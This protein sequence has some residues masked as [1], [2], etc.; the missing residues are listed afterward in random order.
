MARVSDA[1][2]SSPRP[3]EA[4]VSAE[5]AQTV[6]GLV[7]AL[8]DECCLHLDD[9]GVRIPAVDPASVAMV[10]LELS[11]D[12][13][14]AYEAGGGRIGVDVDRLAAVVGMADRGQRV[15]LAL[16]PETRTLEIVIDELEYTLAL[17]D[18]EA[19]RSPPDLSE[20]AV[21][22]TGEAVVDADVI[23][24]ALRAADMVA[25]QIAFGIDADAKTF[26]VEAEGDTDDVSLAL[27]ADD[28]VDFTPGDAHSLFSLDYLNAINRAIADAPDIGLQLG[29]E[30]PIEI[31][32]EFA[33]GAG[34]VEYVVSPRRAVEY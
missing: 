3:F 6:V 9:D 2:E 11:D 29:T 23:D 27:T 14:E 13:F 22:L 8:V 20:T 16:D 10:D 26:Y 30:T 17:I 4:V 18:P 28:L 15:A 31:G 7:G 33:D 24:Q 32:Y 34:A 25:N 12:A 1:E 21:D 19:I 5:T